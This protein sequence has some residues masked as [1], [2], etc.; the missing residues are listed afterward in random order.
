MANTPKATLTTGPVPATITRLAIPMIFGILSIVAFNLVDSFF[1]GMIG[2][3][4][5]AAFGFTFPVVMIL[6]SIGMGLGMGTSAVVSKLIGQNDIAK[7]RRTT[8]DSIILALIFGFAFVI[9]GLLT[10][11]PVFRALGATEDILP[12]IRAYMIPWYLGVIFVIVPMVGISAIRANGDTKTPAFIMISMVV[13]NLIL[14]PMFIFGFG[15]LPAMGLTGA[16]VATV[17]A[18]ML[19]LVMGIYVLHF[20]DGLLTFDIPSF[21]QMLESWKNILYIGLPAAATNLVVPMSTALVTNLVS[22]YGAEAV[23]AFGVA[24]RVDV[25]AVTVLIAVGSAMAPFIG[26]N[27]GAGRIDRIKEGFGLVMKFSIAWGLFMLVILFFLG[28]YIA[29]LFSDDPSVTKII[30]LYLTITPLGY[31]VRGVYTICNTALNVIKKPFQASSITIVQMFV[32]YVPLAYLLSSQIGIKGIFWA[33]AV[34]Y[35]AGGVAGYLMFRKNL[36]TLEQTATTPPE[37]AINLES[38][39][40]DILDL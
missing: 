16:A 36:I 20:R 30:I 5:L 39:R 18:R 2:T 22:T 6:G 19:T 37:D 33:L 17:I 25:L 28:Q 31:G 8:T 15:P 12:L 4:E 21:Q 40:S 34:A 11:D 10:I 24:S 9:I 35:L 32:V 13:V 26:Q 23:A 27:L 14:D 3:M 7:V 29:P 38:G 1:V